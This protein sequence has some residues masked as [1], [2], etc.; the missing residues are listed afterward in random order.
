M[1]TRIFLWMCNYIH[2]KS[3]DVIT[4]PCPITSTAVQRHSWGTCNVIRNYMPR[5]LWDVITYPGHNNLRWT[6]VKE[7]PCQ[8]PSAI[9]QKMRVAMMVILS[10]MAAPQVPSVRSKLASRQPFYFQYN[11]WWLL[12]TLFSLMASEFV[13]TTTNGAASDN[14]VG[15]KTTLWLLLWFQCPV[16]RA[17]SRLVPSQWVTSLQSNA[18]SHWLGANL[19]SVLCLHYVH[20][21]TW[22][23]CFISSLMRG[24]HTF[25]N[26]GKIRGA[27][28][29]KYTTQSW[30]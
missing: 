13:I 1:Y 19:E 3:Y 11:G 16:F 10:S 17:D 29:W 20:P 21:S 6:V 4:Y 23:F 8:Q 5:K 14:K 27:V 7:A 26:S 15:I 30:F 12:P 24:R 18:V 25:H 22:I 2:I 28:E 9:L